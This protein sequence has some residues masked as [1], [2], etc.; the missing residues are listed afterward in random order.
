MLNDWKVSLDGDPDPEG[1]GYVQA[2]LLKASNPLDPIDDLW[3][4]ELTCHFNTPPSATA[5]AGWDVL[6]VTDGGDSWVLQW[7]ASSPEYFILPGDDPGEF[8]LTF[9]ANQSITYGE[10]YT[11]WFGGDNYPEYIPAIYFDNEGGNFPF[12]SDMGSASTPGTAYQTSISLTADDL[13]TRVVGRHI[14]YNNSAFDGDNPNANTADDGAVASDKEALQLGTATFENYT[15][16]SRGI[17]GIIVDIHNLPGT[18]T[19]ADFEFKTGND[20]D[21]ANWAPFLVTP[22]VTVRPGEGVD[23]SR[24]TLIW[25]DNAIE[26]TWLQVT[27]LANDNTGLLYYPDVFYFGNAIAETGDS[28]TNASVDA[29]DI[30]QTRN[31]PHPFFNPAEIYSPYDFDRDQRV[32]AGDILLARNNQTSFFNELELITVPAEKG[33]GERAAAARKTMF[34]SDVVLER[35]GSQE[36]RT[37]AQDHVCL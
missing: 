34:A 8:T 32:D 33:I 15:S 4:Q 22:T 2:F 5:P 9:L 30:L 17:N 13:D 19:D 23:N 16:Y 26:N 14:F 36:S 24:I 31:N 29:N 35:V 11:F 7:E 28:P 18:I 1:I 12:S 6:G 21:P 3:G 25:P 37:G 20:D 27:V 10:D